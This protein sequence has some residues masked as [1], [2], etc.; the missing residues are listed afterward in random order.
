VPLPTVLDNLIAEGA[1]P[2]VVAVLPASLDNETRSRELHMHEPFVA[3]LVDDLLPWARER[4]S[5]TSDPSRVLAVGSSLGGLT[6]AFCGLKRSDVFGLV[7]SQSGAFQRGLPN[8]F[9]AAERLALRFALDVGAFETMSFERMP[10]IYHANLHMRD[11]LVAKGYD[12]SFVEYPGGHD[13][14]CWRE[15]VAD[16]LI[17]LLA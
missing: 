17:A 10:S 16:G 4:I 11:V 3:F 9:A 2:P 7:L 5:F 6:A 12:V 1:I 14:L 15:T 8:E 13:Y